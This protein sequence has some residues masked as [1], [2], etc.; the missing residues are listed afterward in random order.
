MKDE[1]WY[2][3]WGMF[4]LLRRKC[5]NGVVQEELDLKA[6]S[7]AAIQ[8]REHTVVYGYLYGLWSMV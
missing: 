2:Q 3:S 4:G 8:S 1:G 7:V 5:R 6:G